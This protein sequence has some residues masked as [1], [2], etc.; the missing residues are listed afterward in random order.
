MSDSDGVRR[1]DRAVALRL[2]VGGVVLATF[3]FYVNR[4]F[5]EDDSLITLRYCRNLLNGKGLVWNAG[6]RVEGYTNFLYLILVAGLGY[7]GV[8]LAVATRLVGIAS[9]LGIVGVVF[10]YTAPGRRQGFAARATFPVVIALSSCPIIVWSVGGLE[11]SLCAFLS[12]VGVVLVAQNLSL[13]RLAPLAAAGAFFGLAT[14]TR[15]DACLFVAPAVLCLV[16]FDRGRR[17][18][19]GG[20]TVAVAFLG[21]YAPYFGW[22]YRYYGDLFPNTFYAKGTSADVHTLLSGIR[23]TVGVL[24]RPPSMGTWI[25]A[26]LVVAVRKGKSAVSRRLVYLLAAALSYSIFPIFAGGDHMPGSRF[27]VPAI[28]VIALA[29]FEAVCVAGFGAT[30]ARAQVLGGVLLAA[31]ALQRPFRALNPVHADPAVYLGTVVGEYVETHWQAGSLVAINPAGAV[32]YLANNLRFI[33]MLGLNDRHIAHTPTPHFDLIHAEV[34]G[35]R[36]GNGEYV[37][38]R[39]PDFIILGPPEGTTVGVPW[40]VSDYEISA[41]RTEF[42]RLYR[43]EDVDLDVLTRPDHESFPASA[44]GMLHFVFYRRVDAAP[45]GAHGHG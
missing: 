40:F 26:A 12:L 19:L 41:R 45:D 37:L 38:S 23:Y 14:M 1:K 27:M 32:P 31:C 30:P 42:E 44:S 34:P 5:Y 6:E 29:V 28:P 36:K 39:K 35:H 8:D 16:A 24:L 25:I 18:V 2:L 33:D 22:R 17:G 11:G 3:F 10:L 43:K 9:Y 21:I 15:I 7:L 4:R 20:A 13:E